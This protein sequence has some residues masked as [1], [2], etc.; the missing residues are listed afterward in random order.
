MFVNLLNPFF[1]KGEFTMLEWIKELI[2]AITSFFS[3]LLGEVQGDGIGD[4]GIKFGSS[5]LQSLSDW[6]TGRG[7]E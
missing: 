5:W 6:L 2:E 4:E 3:G 1:A 7:A